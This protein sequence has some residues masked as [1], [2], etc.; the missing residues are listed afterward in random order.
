MA[1]RAQRAESP[2][3]LRQPPKHRRPGPM[4]RAIETMV[5][6]Q[7]AVKEAGG[8]GSSST[9]GSAV[10][11]A[12]GLLG[13][14]RQCRWRPG[15]RRLYPNAWYRAS[16]RPARGF[17]GAAARLVSRSS[18]R[19]ISART[20]ASSDV[21]ARPL[22]T[23]R[24]GGAPAPPAVAVT[25]IFTSASGKMTVPMS[26]PSSTAPGGVRPKSRWKPSSAPRTSGMAETTEAASPTAVALQ[27]RL[28]ELGRVERLRRQRPRGRGRP[29]G[30]PPSSNA[31]ATAR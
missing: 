13:R 16:A 30:W 24:H 20:S 10:S 15:M 25:K 26:R 9:S 8:A 4:T 3:D 21:I 22:A 2:A 17:S 11:R 29:S 14:L 23:R 7:C 28:V 18:R 5:Q 6:I 31:F 1:F 19:R 12:S 27:R